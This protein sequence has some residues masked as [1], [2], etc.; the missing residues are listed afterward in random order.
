MEKYDIR[1]HIRFEHKCVGARW[2]ETTSQW[3][4]QIRDLNSDIAFED[5]ADVLMTGEGVLNHWTWPSIPGLQ[6]F[7]GPL[8]HSADWDP[9][10]EPKVLS[11]VS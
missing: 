5:S 9:Q 10:F 11:S 1:K 4:T 3:Y 8:L 6:E 2:S 7:N